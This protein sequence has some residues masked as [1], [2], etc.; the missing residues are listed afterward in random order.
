MAAAGTTRCP[1]VAADGSRRLVG[2]VSPQDLLR[3]R[4]RGLDEA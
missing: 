2:F 3:A 4:I 1:V